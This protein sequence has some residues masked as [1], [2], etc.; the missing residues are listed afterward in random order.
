[1]VRDAVGA[2]V[3]EPT[4]QA[5]VAIPRYAHRP[6]L[7]G[8]AG[9]AHGPDLDRL[10]PPE[11]DDLVDAGR[12]QDLAAVGGYDEAGTA[13]RCQVTQAREIQV[14]VVGVRD[15]DDVDRR[16]PRGRYPRWS[17]PAARAHAT[18]K[19]GVRRDQAP[20]EAQEQ[21]GV[22]DPREARPVRGDR[23]SVVVAPG[24]DEGSPAVAFAARDAVQDLPLEDVAEPVVRDRA[25]H[26]R[27]SPGHRALTSTMPR[28]GTK[29]HSAG[30]VVRSRFKAV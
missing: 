25:V 19:H 27:V 6:V 5:R 7:R 1:V 22:S 10:P 12:A 15:S 17:E 14:V 9:D 26:V 24:R 3:D 16:D 4:P 2:L 28:R 13:A 8:D 21:R 30:A 11:L 29:L 18:C 23:R 20:A